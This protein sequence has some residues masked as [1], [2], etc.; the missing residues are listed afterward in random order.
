[1]AMTKREQAEMAELRTRLGMLEA[2]ARQVEIPA[3]DLPRPTI[4]MNQGWDYNIYTKRVE[5]YTSESHAHYRGAHLFKRDW[6]AHSWSQGGRD[7]YSSKKLALQA[8]RAAMQRT[9]ATELANIDR[10]LA[11]EG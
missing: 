6:D 7:L 8:L 9:H 10:Q 4:G 1:M 5:P 3:K 11:Q 2:L